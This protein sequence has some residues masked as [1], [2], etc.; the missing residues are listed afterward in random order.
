MQQEKVERKW[1]VRFAAVLM[2]LGTSFGALP[3]IKNT[4]FPIAKTR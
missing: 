2:I 1:F 3:I 4:L